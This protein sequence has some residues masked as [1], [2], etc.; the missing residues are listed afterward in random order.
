M[1]DVEILPSELA[2]A[3]IEVLR[4]VVQVESALDATATPAVASAR[5][6][7]AVVA[8][9]IVKRFRFHFRNPK[10][11]SSR[12][13]KLHWALQFILDTVRDDADFARKFLDPAFGEG[14]EGL[15]A[16]EIAKLLIV[17]A[18]EKIRDDLQG[19]GDDASLL[20]AVTEILWFV[21]EVGGQLKAIRGTLPSLLDLVFLRQPQS[22]L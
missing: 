14:L 20:P 18:A 10:V 15:C 19:T 7:E 11:E 21:G 4:A 22:L 2:D 12:P 8:A 5:V 1:R 13:D 17:E 16:A 6:V 3:L 9:P